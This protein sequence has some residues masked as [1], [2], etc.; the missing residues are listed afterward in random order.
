MG[1]NMK[2]SR[3]RNI[4]R[5]GALIEMTSPLSIGTAFT[6]QL[7]FK[8]SVLIKCVVRRVEPGR[9]IGVSIIAPGAEGRK[10]LAAFLDTLARE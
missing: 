10:R 6:A 1:K 9:G 4:G 5:E 8:P 3:V 2:N 7:A